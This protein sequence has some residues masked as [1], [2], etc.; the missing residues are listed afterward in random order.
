[1]NI[2]PDVVADTMG[3]YSIFRDFGLHLA[4]VEAVI[5]GNPPIAIGWRTQMHVISGKVSR[6]GLMVP[7]IKED[8]MTSRK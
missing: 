6:L 4:Y 5:A 2:A 1:M 8:L 7:M 3:R